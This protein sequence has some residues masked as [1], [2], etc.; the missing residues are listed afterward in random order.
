[1]TDD[2]V[3]A[4]ALGGNVAR[5]LSML[6]PG[7]DAEGGRM[8]RGK[9]VSRLFV[10]N[11]YLPSFSFFFFYKIYKTT[12]VIDKKKQKP[13]FTRLGILLLSLRQPRAH[14]AFF[15]FLTSP[16]LGRG[17]ALLPSAMFCFVATEEG[18]VEYMLLI[19]VHELAGGIKV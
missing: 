18:F 8:R 9:R 12:C 19:N 5:P 17:D 2:G 11:F 16:W 6:P 13:S 10:P 3:L 14:A 4:R 15:V 7:L 1:M